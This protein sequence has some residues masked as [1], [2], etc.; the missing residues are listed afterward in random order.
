MQATKAPE[1]ATTNQ[2]PS[3]KESA[4][5]RQSARHVTSY[6]SKQQRTSS[7]AGG[8]QQ[9]TSTRPANHCERSAEN[10]PHIVQL[11]SPIDDLS[12][13]SFRADRSLV[14]M[15]Q[16]PYCPP[17]SLLCSF[18]FPSFYFVPLLSSQRSHRCQQCYY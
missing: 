7:Q 18:S 5:R 3:S 6:P 12:S 17:F 13:V 4:S 14:C 16:T 11:R 10:L 8:N 2:L 15:V 1:Q 9:A